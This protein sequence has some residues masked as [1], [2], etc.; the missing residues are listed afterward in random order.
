MDLEDLNLNNTPTSLPSTTS[1]AYLDDIPSDLVGK[2]VAVVTFGCAHNQAD[3]EIIMGV[4]AAA[5]FNIID[6]NPR[7][8]LSEIESADCV[9][10]NGCT[11][12]DISEHN[13]F[14][15]VRTARSKSIPTIVAGCV[16]QA[17]SRDSRLDGI[18]NIGTKGQVFAAQA[19]VAALLGHAF[20]IPKP[21]SIYSVETVDD[22]SEFCGNPLTL[23]SRRRHP[24]IEI[25]PI[26]SGCVSHC[27]LVSY[28]LSSI[29]KRAV[30]AAKRD[31]VEIWFT[32]EDTGAYGLDWKLASVDLVDLLEAVLPALEPYNCRLRIGHA[33]PQHVARILPRFMSSPIVN[34]PRL[35]RFIHLPLQSGSDSVLTDMQRDHDCGT[36]KSAATAL[37]ELRF[38]IS[39]DII[40]SYPTELEQDHQ[41]TLTVLNEIEPTFTN[42]TQFFPRRGTSAFRMKR[43]PSDTVKRRSKEIHDWSAAFEPFNHL[44]NQE[45]VCWVYGKAHDGKRTACHSIGYL[46]VL[47]EGEYPVGSELTIR[48]V[49]FRDVTVKN[50]PPLEHMF[51]RPKLTASRY[52][53]NSNLLPSIRFL[54][55]PV[56]FSNQTSKEDLPPFRKSQIKS[57]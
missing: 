47:V 1:P 42:I 31:A 15:A 48:H 16:A 33:N 11:V 44:V 10:V 52:I 24:N 56:L 12:V 51:S 21:K 19:V 38:T 6:V 37:Q 43:V 5:S 8:N 17:S 35:F 4:L 41:D 55:A 25:I 54:S 3:S 27:K 23:P 39:T 45:V 2:T 30:D 46:Q 34:H 36:W 57:T 22:F 13:F 32:G 18:I 29:V 14:K 28:P 26:C 50:T 9:V 49:L 53:S 7:Q 20:S 40:V